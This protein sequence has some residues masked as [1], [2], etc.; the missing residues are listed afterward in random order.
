MRKPA[1]SGGQTAL[2][3]STRS[4]TPLRLQTARLT[5][6][7]GTLEL[8]RAETHDRRELAALLGV[9][10]PN[11]WPPPLNDEN[12]LAWFLR[13]LEE[14]PTIVGWATWYFLRGGSEDQLPILI[15]NGGFFGRPGADGTV[16][17]GYSIL[18]AHQRRGYAPEAVAALVN[19]A[20]TT[21][22]VRRITAHTLPELRPSIRVL[23]KCGFRLLGPGAEEGTIQFERP[24]RA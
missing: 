5:L 19:W 7:A 11:N 9:P 21:P 2:H 6:V 3:D 4:P 20:F 22:A 24:R 15:G 16:E 8:A 13:R 17:I 14:D 1:D 23:E 10:S 18:P 12:S